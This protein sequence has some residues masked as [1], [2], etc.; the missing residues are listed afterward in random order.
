MNKNVSETTSKKVLII[1]DEE[2]LRDVLTDVMEM[3]DI[4]SYV[5]GGGRQGVEMYKKHKNEIGLVLLDI[6]MPDESGFETYQNLCFINPDVNVIFMSGYSDQKSLPKFSL[7]NGYAF[8]EKPFSM[9][10]ITKKI[11]GSLKSNDL[12]YSP[13]FQ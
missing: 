2:I 4:D 6:L 7:D 11:R 10:E 3:I 9:D 5:A 13:N 1:D 8:I 12:N